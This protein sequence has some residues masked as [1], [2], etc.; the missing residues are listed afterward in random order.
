[1]SL[2]NC[3]ICNKQNCLPGVIENNNNNSL[4][5]CS[6][7]FNIQFN[8]NNNQLFSTNSFKSKFESLEFKEETKTEPEFPFPDKLD[9]YYIDIKKNPVPEWVSKSKEIE[10]W[11]LNWCK[12]DDNYNNYM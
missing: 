11:Y 3:P 5:I 10:K 1:M 2:I 8:N 7:C 6:E 4:I 12:W 9:Q